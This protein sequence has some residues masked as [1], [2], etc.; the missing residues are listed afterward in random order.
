[1]K[2]DR[3]FG[4]CRRRRDCCAAHRHDD[5]SCGARND[6]AAT[7]HNLHGTYLAYN[8]SGGKNTCTYHAA[9]SLPPLIRQARLHGLV[10]CGMKEKASPI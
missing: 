7:P 3:I 2:C 9:Q 1:M 8:T 10:A 6:D 5:S 4:A